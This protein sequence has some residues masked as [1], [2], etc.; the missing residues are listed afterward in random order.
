MT[1]S[2]KFVALLWDFVIPVYAVIWIAANSFEL[3]DRLWLGVPVFL[4]N[5]FI[6]GENTN[7]FVDGEWRGSKKV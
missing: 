3:F 4:I 5:A 6:L 1:K 7:K 2:R